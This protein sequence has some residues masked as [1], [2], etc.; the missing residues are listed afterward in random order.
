LLTFCRSVI[1]L[2]VERR[3]NLDSDGGFPFVVPGALLGLT[4]RT[5]DINMPVVNPLARELVFKVVYYGPGLSGK[6][7]SLQHIHAT[8]RPERRGKMVSLATPVDRTLYFDFLP[9]RVP[10]SRDMTVRLQLF[11]V[12]GQVYYNATRKL[13]LTGADG[14]V[15]VVDSQRARADA[16]I[17]S[18]R[19]LEENL[20]EHGRALDE[21]P[22]VFSYNKRDLPN[23]VPIDDMERL[24]NPRGA[25]SFATVSTTGEGVYETLEAITRAVLED[26]ERRMPEHR[27][28]APSNMMLPEGGLAEALRQADAAAESGAAQPPPTAIANAEGPPSADCG[29]PLPEADDLGEQVARMLAGAGT[30]PANGLGTEAEPDP[31]TDELSSPVD[32]MSRVM[33][34]LAG[35]ARRAGADRT[36]AT[37]VRR[38]NVAAESKVGD[39]TERAGGLDAP[40]DPSASVASGSAAPTHE[41]AEPAPTARGF[42]LASLWSD[43]E[44]PTVLR[45]EDCIQ[46][47]ALRDAVLLMDVLVQ[48]SIERLSAGWTSALMEPSVMMLMLGMRGESIMEFRGL[49][50]RSRGTAAS[51]TEDQ[52]KI[53][54]L[55]ATELQ[56]S[57]RR[58]LK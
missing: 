6:T 50:E 18:L 53:A 31:A 15:F 36:E 1:G 26:F 42:S 19:N 45:V 12:P 11:T 20:T 37:P 40:E 28:L 56:L 44:R 23:L 33:A 4:P 54:L 41:T 17:E 43:D 13:V 38:T 52:A 25:P 5:G 51:P 46:E 8:A 9:I 49:C 35:G 24:L 22:H 47:G 57:V 27:G 14:I 30:V 7:T 21:I 58:L 34:T 48:R 32:A 29:A 10:S 39:R 55:F 2:V 16:N 3:T